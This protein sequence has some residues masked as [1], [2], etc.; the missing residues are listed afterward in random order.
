MIFVTIGS[1]FPFDRLIKTIDDLV[2]AWP[3]E[4][5]LAQIG[6]GTYEPK[7]MRFLRMLTATEFNDAV[8]SSRLIV[9]HA[10]MG[11][12]ITAMETNIPIVIVPRRMEFDEH[13]TDHQMATAR[14]LAGRK[15][16]YVVLEDASIRDV[17]DQAL[18]DGAA[19]GGGMQPSAPTAF[20]DKIRNYIESV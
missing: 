14:W 2:P 6:E 4:Q 20:L 18:S 5:F 3:E 11:S 17:I 15:G 8:K 1:L 10:G 19:A 16:V 12:V 13:T 9:A 7:N